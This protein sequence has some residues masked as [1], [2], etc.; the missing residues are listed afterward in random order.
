MI[1]RKLDYIYTINGW[2]K[3][4]NH[5]TLDS[6]KDAGG[7]GILGGINQYVAKD[8]LAFQLQYF[9]GD[10]KVIG[11]FS[12]GNFSLYTG[13]FNGNIG[14]HLMQQ[15]TL[16]PLTHAYQYDALNR[17]RSRSTFLNNAGIQHYTTSYTYDKMGNILTLNRFASNAPMDS[18]QYFYYPGSNKLNHVTD[19]V[20]ASN[21]N[22][23]IDSQTINNYIYDPTGNLI[24][25]HSE[26]LEISWTH[27]GKVKQ[28]KKNNN[29]LLSFEYDAMGNRLVKENKQTNEKQI[30]IRDA[31][32]NVM[33]IYKDRNDSLFLDEL[34]LYGSSRLGVIKEDSFLAKK[35][36]SFFS[37]FKTSTPSTPYLPSIPKSISIGGSITPITPIPLPYNFVHY[38]FGKKHYELADWLGNVRVVIND[39]KTPQGTNPSN[40]TYAA[41][42]LEVSDYYPFGS[43]LYGRRWSVGYRY[44]FNRKEMDNEVKGFGNDYDYG[45]R[46]YDPRVGRWLSVD[47]LAKNYVPIS[48]YVF[49]I[50]NPIKLLD[51]DGKVVVDGN[52]NPVTI[53]FTKGKDGSYTANFQFVE[54]T[55]KEVMEG[56]MKNAGTVIK[57]MSKTEIGRTI[58]QAMNDAQHDIAIKIDKRSL[59]YNEATKEYSDK[60]SD[61]FI[62]LYGETKT[63]VEGDKIISSEITIFE[64]TINKIK[65]TPPN[66]IWVIEI[67]GKD[68]FQSDFS[69][70]EIIGAIGTHEG[71]HATDK[72][73]MRNLGVDPKKAE[74][75]PNANELKYYEQADPRGEKVHE[76]KK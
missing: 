24:K 58:V 63:K 46:H 70:D 69:K 11:N 75:K 10:Y 18:L 48:P 22:N 55:S 23:D 21:F 2:M 20:P 45:D 47:K 31:Q 33:S 72:G 42:V 39:K 44:G 41:Q 62:P 71:T 35:Y 27:Y 67:N 68:V 15:D 29:N 14:A 36:P 50:N 32:G 60:P 34:H 73:S 19:N 53:S 26:G 64:G 59:Y 65:E 7:D 37:P 51:S 16:T 6:S 17:L 54:G 12:A 66:K 25:D 30:Y 49:A 1:D 57:A 61:G 52:G 9:H 74:D 3:S 56:F 38:H 43:P 4:L 8:K 13:L 40:M 28:I 76:K 5:S